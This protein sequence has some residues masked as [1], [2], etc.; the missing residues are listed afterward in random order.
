M[1]ATSTSASAKGLA[2]VQLMRFHRPVGIW[3]LLWP[4][5]WALWFASGGMPPERW[6]II[7]ALGV[8]V[9]RAAGCVINDICDYR[10]DREV[11]RT[12]GRPLAAGTLKL[13]DAWVSFGILCLMGF[14]L[15]WQLPLLAKGITGIALGLS[16]LY[17]LAKRFFPC[18]QL[19]LGLSWYLGMVAAYATLLGYV[20][21]VAW[22]VYGAAVVWTLAYDTQYALADIIDDTKLGLHSSARWFGRHAHAAV[23]LLQVL[24]L[25]M[26]TV[27]G[28]VYQVNWVY[29]LCLG[30]SALAFIYQYTLM[31]RQAYLRAFTHNQWVGLILFLGVV[32][33]V[34]C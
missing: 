31:Q 18:P 30:L 11:L 32:A 23:I 2:Y 19:I 25:G 26:M 16:M 20:P 10:Y 9:M 3:L 22:F 12:Q 24:F 21:P 7:F 28:W 6:S 34:F 17:P 8:V 5:L 33:Q 4:T 14:G 13:S 27:V 29:Y 15:W 1:I